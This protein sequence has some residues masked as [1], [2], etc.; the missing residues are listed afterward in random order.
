MRDKGDTRLAHRPEAYVPTLPESRGT[1]RVCAS[2]WSAAVYCRF[3]HRAA[4]PN[5]FLIIFEAFSHNG[6]SSPTDR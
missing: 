6:V 3:L 4:V 1:L 2:S 5:R